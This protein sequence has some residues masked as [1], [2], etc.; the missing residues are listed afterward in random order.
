MLRNNDK[1]TYSQRAVAKFKSRVRK[2]A[3]TTLIILAII[4]LYFL[5]VP[6]AKFSKLPRNSKS[7]VKKMKENWMDF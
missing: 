2:C 7:K 3:N 6:S 5:F 4:A 1:Q